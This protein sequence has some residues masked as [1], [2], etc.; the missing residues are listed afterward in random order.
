MMDHAENRWKQGDYLG[1]IQDYRLIIENHSKSDVVDE[2]YYWI[3]TIESLNLQD[4]T[5]AIITYRNLIR[6][7]PDSPYRIKAHKAIAEI[8]AEKMNMPGN[9][10]SEYEKL[11]DIATQSSL[12]E[13]VRYRI[14]E[15]YVELHDLEQARTEWGFLL[16]ETPRSAWADNALY[17]I[18]STH[19]LEGQFDKALNVYQSLLGLYPDTELQAEAHLGIAS[20]LEETEKLQ[21]ALDKYRELIDD[22]PNPEVI[23]F[24]IKN[25]ERRLKDVSSKTG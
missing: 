22:Y 3:G 24:R 5:S 2:A 12:K 6:D 9:A 11:I 14:G 21:E 20:C 13:E 15:A 19:F 23:Q 7:F 16:K 18:G 25:L 17:H 8:Y 1:A 10:I 4:Y